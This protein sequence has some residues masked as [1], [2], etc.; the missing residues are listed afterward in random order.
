MGLDI[1]E[2]TRFFTSLS[3]VLL[4]PPLLFLPLCLPLPSPSLYSPSPLLLP[5]APPDQV[6]NTTVSSE[7]LS[8]RR[9]QLTWDAPEDN[10][11]PITNYWITYCIPIIDST[12]DTCVGQT[13]ISVR[14]PTVPMEELTD[15]NPLRR[16]RVTIQAENVAGRGPESQPYFFDS[17]SAGRCK[18]V[19]P[20][21]WSIRWR[22]GL[23]NPLSD[24]P[25]SLRSS[26][27]KWPVIHSNIKPETLG[28]QYCYKLLTWSSNIQFSEFAKSL[29][30][31]D[32]RT[33][34]LLYISSHDE[35]YLSSVLQ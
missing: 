1:L 17:A 24:W 12:N 5:P 33:Y 10:N 3:L 15:I 13:T 8:L 11:A 29:W 28:T 19:T 35:M 31:T 4:P 34:C 22:Y 27:D 14:D 18:L 7:N 30:L 32:S 26:T 16:Y 6:D 21:I 25:D 9:T 2:T 23:D 20:V